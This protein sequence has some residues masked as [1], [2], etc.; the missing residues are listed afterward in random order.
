V[1]FALI[2]P[3]WS[4]KLVQEALRLLLEAYYEHQ[5]S[6]R[7]HGFRPNLGCHTALREIT[8]RW[9]GVKWFVEGD[10]KGCYDNIDHQ[11]LLSILAEDIHDN[12]FLRLISNMLKA[13]YLK[14][15]RYHATLSGTPQGSIASPILA[16]IYLNKLDR[17]VEETLLPAFNRGNRRRVNP[18]Y[19]ALLRAAQRAGDKGDHETAKRLR[20]QAQTM[21]SRDPNDPD[22]R[23]L[24]YVRYA[25]DTLLGFSGPRSEAEE[26]KRRIGAFLRNELRLEL[27]AEKTLITHA[28]TRAARFLG[29]EVVTLDA[30][31]KHD[32]RGQRCINGTVRLRGPKDVIVE[33]CRSYMMRKGKAVHRPERLVDDGFSI[34]SQYEAE[35]RGFAQY[36]LPAFNAHR[37]WKVHRVMRPSLLG[38]LANKHKTKISKIAR[39]MQ[40]V[41]KNRGRAIKALAI[42]KPRGESKKPL[43]A[44]FGAISL[45]WN[46]DALITDSPKQVYNG[47][48]S[49]LVQ[50][51][52]AE[53]CELCRAVDGPFEVHHI[54]RLADLDRPG[55]KEKPLWVKRMASRQRK[56]LVTCTRCHQDI[57]RDRSGWREK[58]RHWKAG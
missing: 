25:D 43:V 49:E 44:M 45:A 10:I 16:N 2:V 52:L 56:T 13:G 24:W 21:P 42:E 22:F 46:K 12:R 33:R 40:T 27:S 34:V 11:V 4:D 53:V 41:V 36:Y 18:A 35:Y 29:F 15:W 17:F 38:T 9:R 58:T 1:Q 47:L 23:R 48:R 39:H 5:F 26:I 51:L 32:R 57:H 8:Q 55:Q 50:R 14:V 30:D 54:R 6:D 31:H 7:S 3:S 20:Q 37:L 28:R 19:M